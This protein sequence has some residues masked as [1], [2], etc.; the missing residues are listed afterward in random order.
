[1]NKITKK[2]KATSINCGI[3]M[4]LVNVEVVYHPLKKFKSH[5]M[6][7]ALSKAI[8]NPSKT[9]FFFGPGAIKLWKFY[10]IF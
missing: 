7:Q 10:C 9:I 8:S 3:Q 6:P 2:R 1:M 4:S 5:L